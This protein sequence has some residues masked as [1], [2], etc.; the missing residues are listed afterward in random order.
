MTQCLVQAVDPDRFKSF[1]SASAVFILPDDRLT[2][3]QTTRALCHFY[4]NYHS[5]VVDIS[6]ALA[7]FELL[8]LESAPTIMRSDGW[9]LLGCRHPIQWIGA[10]STRLLSIDVL[11]YILESPLYDRIVDRCIRF[12]YA[13]P[14]ASCLVSLYASSTHIDAVYNTLRLV[15][16]AGGVHVAACPIQS[17]VPRCT[18]VMMEC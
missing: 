10:A 2:L 8:L 12:G 3:V 9:L 5:E 16:T 4:E 17:I 13:G 1:L 18:A 15:T 14:V 6:R 11:Q 7:F